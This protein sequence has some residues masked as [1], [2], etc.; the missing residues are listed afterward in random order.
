[1]NNKNSIKVLYI[2]TTITRLLIIYN[3][4]FF[5]IWSFD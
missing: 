1:M 2:G 3:F 4:H 5:I